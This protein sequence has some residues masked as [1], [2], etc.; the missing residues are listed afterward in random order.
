[1]EEEEEGGGTETGGELVVQMHGELMRKRGSEKS[2]GDF[3]FFFDSVTRLFFLSSANLHFNLELKG[4]TTHTHK[5]TIGTDVYPH[6]ALQPWGLLAECRCTPSPSRPPSLPPSPPL[7][8][9]LEHS[10]TSVI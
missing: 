5:R 1:M 6:R 7:P 4:G 3:L 8:S 10:L 2:H 9:P